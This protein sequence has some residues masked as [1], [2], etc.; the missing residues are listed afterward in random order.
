MESGSG[1]E[2]HPR[3]ARHAIDSMPTIGTFKN[4]FRPRRAEGPR[5]A[6]ERVEKTLPG[7]SIIRAGVVA[8]SRQ[9]QPSKVKGDSPISATHEIEQAVRQIKIHREAK[10]N[11]ESRRL[12]AS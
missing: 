2:P 1:G 4:A 7:V 5:R 9:F 3:E 6:K 11:Q 10:T 12:R 8:P